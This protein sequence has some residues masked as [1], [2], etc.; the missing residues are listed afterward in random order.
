MQERDAIDGGDDAGDPVPLRPSQRRVEVHGLRNHEK[1][2][3]QPTRLHRG[4]QLVSA[5]GHRIA[6]RDDPES[7]R[8]RQRLVEQLHVLLAQSGDEAREAGH[9]GS[10]LGQALH[11]SLRDRI[12]HEGHDDRYGGGRPSR[13]A[14][15][16]WSR[17]HDG[18]GPGR[19]QL[20]EHAGEAA[21][22]PKARLTTRFRPST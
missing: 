13:R 8:R 22:L 19:D 15:L 2:H 11:E 14:S 21:R 5:L 18:V 16:S 20:G 3:G 1:R 9:I 10:R 12:L 6:R 17:R 4:L 7:P